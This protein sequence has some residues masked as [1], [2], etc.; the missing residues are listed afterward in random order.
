MA[1]LRTRLHTEWTAPIFLF[2]AFPL[3]KLTDA[4]MQEF[5]LESE[6]RRIRG[7]SPGLLPSET[8]PVFMNF[9]GVNF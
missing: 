1:T 6:Y 9:A 3:H 5:K 8:V 7:T 2:L 4:N